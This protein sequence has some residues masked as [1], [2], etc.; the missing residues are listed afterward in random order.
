MTIIG[1][2]SQCG[3]QV[4]RDMEGNMTCINCGSF[5]PA[6]PIIHMPP[7]RPIDIPNQRYPEWS[8][9]PYTKPNWL[10]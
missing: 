3:G 8:R 1:R 2:C 4:Q 7:T 10:I 9:P 5:R 6:L